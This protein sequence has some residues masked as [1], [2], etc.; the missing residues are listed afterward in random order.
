MIVK[1]KI[2]DSNNGKPVPYASISIVDSSGKI[3][4]GTFMADNE[5]N[6]TVNSKEL[7]QEDTYMQVTSVGYQTDV[8]MPGEVRNSVIELKASDGNMEP[9]VIAYKKPKPLPAKPNYSVPI[10][11]GAAAVVTIGIYFFIK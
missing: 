2:I 7:D 3:A 5:G 6:V 8:F 9:I 4:G 1:V 11:L 10:A